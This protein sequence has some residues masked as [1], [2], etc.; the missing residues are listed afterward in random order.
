MADAQS[1]RTRGSQS[2]PKNSR[3]RA[4]TAP[5][6]QPKPLLPRVQMHVWC[7]AA[8]LCAAPAHRSSPGTD[9]DDVRAP[10]LDCGQM[11]H[12]RSTA[13][14]ALFPSHSGRDAIH[15]APR[16]ARGAENRLTLPTRRTVTGKR[17]AARWRR[18]L[19]DLYQV[20]GRQRTTKL[21][22]E[23]S[24][25]KPSKQDRRESQFFC[26]ARDFGVSVRIIS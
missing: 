25:G 20:L 13:F 8:R 15:V 2:M 16:S 1:L 11:R 10:Q 17:C 26:Q 6:P 18:W 3:S 5:R 24:F 22:E 14:H 19:S 21:L 9:A 23:T 4:R 12:V 7:F